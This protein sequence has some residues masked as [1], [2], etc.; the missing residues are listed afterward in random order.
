M[1]E[2]HLY[3]YGEIAADA[4]DPRAWGGPQI[5]GTNWLVSNL[6]SRPEAEAIVMH[7]NSPGGDVVEGFAMHDILV[8]SG[9]KITTVVE[10]RAASIA[11]V[12]ALAGSVRKITKN[13]T[14]LIHNPWQDGYIGDADH[15]RAVAEGL[16]TVEQV[17]AAFYNEKTGQ[18]VDQLLAYMKEEKEFRADEAQ[19]LGFFT[20]VI[21]TVSAKAYVTNIND[22]SKTL[23]D[24]LNA[25]KKAFVGAI[26]NADFATADGQTLTVE[27]AGTEPAEGDSVSIAGQPAPDGD[28]KL[29]DGKTVTVAG[30]KIT[31]VKP[32]EQPAAAAP[33]APANADNAQVL[34]TVVET[35]ATLANTVKD[36]QT[37]VQGIQNSQTQNATAL[38]T[39]A[40]S[41]TLIG[42]TMQSEGF[43]KVL[44]R[45]K[46]NEDGNRTPKNADEQKAS[47]IEAARKKAGLKKPGE[48]LHIKKDGEE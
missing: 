29:A 6:N 16:E 37:T 46:F 35:V 34:N 40:D 33:P 48:K 22:M 9:K 31:A 41:L 23:I 27:T 36:L 43:K 7:I 3:L 26:K 15:F 13:S 12:V 11:T 17:I 4:G 14:F 42:T 45:N 1:K 25:A 10:G 47:A 8:N 20:E 21:E 44:N 19:A 2:L 32:A 18:S 38:E 5:F 30:G 28:Y 24:R 39:V